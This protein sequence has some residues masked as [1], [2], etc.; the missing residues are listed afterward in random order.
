MKPALFDRYLDILG[1]EP[2]SPNSGLLTELVSAQLVAAPFENISKLHRLRTTGS[3]TIPDLEEYLDGI[4]NWRLGGTCYANNHHFFAL[5]EWLG[6][7]V[8]L[9]G[10]DMSEA[11][12]HM[13]SMVNLGG[14]EFMIDVGYAAPFY[15]PI[16]R[17]LD[18]AHIIDFGRC[19]YVF[20]PQDEQRRSRLEL[21]RDGVS[22]HGYLA[23]PEPRPLTHFDQAVADSF[24]PDSTF[25]NALVIERFT[26]DGGSTRIHN[27][28]LIETPADGPSVTTKLADRDH[29]I[30]GIEDRFGVPSEVVRTAV[31]GVDLEADIYN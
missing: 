11:D 28:S 17:D 25:M 23:K 7:P 26:P 6:F 10:A 18:K 13:V 22:I 8:S 20:H 24:R 19:R 27:L 4:E 14:R 3:T 29:L 30:G 31:E 9:C 2:G 15:K 16:P 12:V 21:F 5:I 1:V